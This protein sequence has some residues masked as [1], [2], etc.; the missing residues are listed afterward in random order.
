MKK[1]YIAG[2]IG[3][4]SIDVFTKN[5]EDAKKEV[6]SLGMI[7]I[8][9]TDLPHNHNRSWSSYMKEDLKAMMD[10]DCIYVQRNWRSSPGAT[11]EID[12]AV[13]LGIDIIF[14]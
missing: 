9:P 7:P 5:F 10:C 3:D 12:V 8:S 1:C 13:S 2:K 14:Q 4:L 6:E 11:M